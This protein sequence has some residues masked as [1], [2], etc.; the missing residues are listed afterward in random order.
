MV[1]ETGLGSFVDLHLRQ[2]TEAH[3]SVFL[4]VPSLVIVYLLAY[5]ADRRLRVSWQSFVFAGFLTQEIGFY[6]G[7][8]PLVN[9]CG[10][11]THVLLP[12]APSVALSLMVM[13]GV[14]LT[15]LEGWKPPRWSLL[16]VYM[17]YIA[18]VITGETLLLD[19]SWRTIVISWLWGIGAGG[20]FLWIVSL[21]YDTIAHALYMAHENVIYDVKLDH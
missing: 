20:T 12:S 9:P 19:V 11:G 14:W 1:C 21:M 3:R 16:I 15:V 13:F 5:L 7:Q 6:I 2:L 10:E 4:F 17:L 18:L 8:A